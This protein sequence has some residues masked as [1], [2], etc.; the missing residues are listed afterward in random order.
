M[1]VDGSWVR[2]LVVDN[3]KRVDAIKNKQCKKQTRLASILRWSGRTGRK[4]S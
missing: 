4:K 3:I 2:V 1:S